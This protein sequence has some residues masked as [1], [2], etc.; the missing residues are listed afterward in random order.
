MTQHHQRTV[1][2][3]F[4]V[5]AAGALIAVSLSVALPLQVQASPQLGEHGVSVNNGPT[6]LNPSAFVVTKGQKG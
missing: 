2:G 4:G 6:Q 5:L 3:Q 1:A